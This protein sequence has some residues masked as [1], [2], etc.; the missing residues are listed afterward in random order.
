TPALAIDDEIVI[1]GKVAKP[2]EIAQ[3]LA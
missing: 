2:E 1:E 3:L